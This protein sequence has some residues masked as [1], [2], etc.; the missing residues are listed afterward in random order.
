MRGLQFLLAETFIHVTVFPKSD[1]KLGDSAFNLYPPIE[2]KLKPLGK[3]HIL[4]SRYGDSY[5]VLKVGTPPRTKG[6]P[7]GRDNQADHVKLTE[8]WRLY[9]CLNTHFW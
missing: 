6:K 1:L 3:R 5:L 7:M 2:N 4:A 8:F 9:T